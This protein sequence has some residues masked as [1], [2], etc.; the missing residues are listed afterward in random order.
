MCTNYLPMQNHV[1]QFL[2]S[3]SSKTSVE[4]STNLPLHANSLPN[5]PHLN[6]SVEA[7][8]YKIFHT[9][10]GELLFKFLMR[11]SITKSRNT[12]TLLWNNPTSL[13]TYIQVPAREVLFL[14]LNLLI[15][16]LDCWRFELNWAHK[17]HSFITIAVYVSTF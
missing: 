16:Y 15:L 13:N 14:A 12:D 2:P 11:K 1:F 8:T 10:L 6:I 4:P 7:R 3:K 5:E 9:P 17:L